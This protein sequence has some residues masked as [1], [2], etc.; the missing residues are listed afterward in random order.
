MPK[1]TIDSLKILVQ[2]LRTERNNFRAMYEHAKKASGVEK[3]KH[4]ITELRAIIKTQQE[5]IELQ[6][7]QIVALKLRVEELERIIW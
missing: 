5:V 7:E 3:L 6:Q 4:T 1:H 2:S